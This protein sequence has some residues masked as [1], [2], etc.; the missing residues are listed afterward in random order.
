MRFWLVLLLWLPVARAL[1]LVPELNLN[2]NQLTPEQRAELFDLETRLTDYLSTVDWDPDETTL[3]LR[4][5]VAIQVRSA[6]ETGS[7]TEYMALFATGNKGDYS[8]DDASWRF[9][10]PDGRFEHNEDSFDSFLSLI[11]FH[12]LLVLGHEYDKLAEFGGNAF[13]ERARRL[14]SQ[15]MF[16]EQQMGWDKRTEQLDQLLDMRNKDFRTLRWVT[17]TALWFRTVQTSPYD[18]WKAAC[19]ALDLAERIDNPSQLGPWYKANSR[20]LI[21]IFEQGKDSDS[22][23]RLLRMD[24][25][26]PQRSEAYRDAISRLN[27]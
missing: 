25:L 6:V 9:R 5:P 18:A 13:Y 23:D 17:H 16:S 21:E 2:L 26:D 20:S 22:L 10:L 24:N 3:T 4:I 7:A 1:T 14:G 12:I 15:A 19:L 27:R 8:V 11:D